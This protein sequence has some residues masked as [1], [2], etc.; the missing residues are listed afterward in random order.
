MK[1]EE[2]IEAIAVVAEAAVDL[3]DAARAVLRAADEDRATA[4]DDALA[5][6]LDDLAWAL[7]KADA[8]GTKGGAL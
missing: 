1:N 3:Y 4:L 5:A 6:A 8:C 2:A 7:A